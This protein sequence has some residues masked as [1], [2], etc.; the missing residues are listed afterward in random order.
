MDTTSK[1]L[2]S[3]MS[4]V[5]IYPSL[6]YYEHAKPYVVQLQP[7]TTVNSNFVMRQWN[8]NVFMQS[9]KA[10]NVI[11]HESGINTVDIDM[12]KK[13]RRR[14]KNRIYG[15]QSR[16]RKALKLQQT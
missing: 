3:T 11:I 10:V 7:E 8:R 9:A 6:E 14:E 13:E 16:A 1:P 4:A 15:Q 2:N 12:F 5:M